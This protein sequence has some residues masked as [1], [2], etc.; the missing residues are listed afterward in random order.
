[1]KNFPRFMT[2]CSIVGVL[3]L[4]LHARANYQFDAIGDT[5]YLSY[6]Q[7]LSS[8]VLGRTVWLY[9]EDQTNGPHHPSGILWDQFHVITAGHVKVESGMTNTILRAGLGSNSLTNQGQTANVA[10]VVV[11]PTWLTNFYHGNTLDIAVLT[12]DRPLSGRAAVVGPAPAPFDSICSC[13][14]FGSIGSYNGGNRPSDGN[15]RGWTM[16]VDGYGGH[17]SFDDWSLDYIDLNAYDLNYPPD[18]PYPGG[19]NNGDSGGGIYDSSGRV[20]GIIVSGILG[21]EVDTFATRLDVTQP[22]IQSVIASEPPH[23]FSIV[24]Q[25]SDLLLNWHGVGGSNY[26]MQAAS[27]LGGTNT[28]TDISGIITLPGSG[29]VVTNYLDAGTL[30]NQP[31]RFYRIR[32]N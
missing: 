10:A 24:P 6:G 20:V 25:G 7:Q 21:I 26:V 12:L 14:G 32:T 8:N 17:S 3:V 27:A 2:A 11:H 5:N 9:I 1:M 13:L 28:F 18:G 23:I 31:A 16:T 19:A 4:A 15:I 30:T 29:T 22:W